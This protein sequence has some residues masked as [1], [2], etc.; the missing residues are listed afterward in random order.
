MNRQRHANLAIDLA[1]IV[2]GRLGLVGKGDE[3]DR[4]PT[5]DELDRIISALETNIRQQIPVDRIIRFCGRNS[6]AARR[7]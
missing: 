7:N 4:R 2:L 3:R 1:R 6:N 5:P